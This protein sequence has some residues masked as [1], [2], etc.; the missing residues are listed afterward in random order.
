VRRLA[1]PGKCP[2]RESE[3]YEKYAEEHP[4]GPRTAKALYEAAYRQCV[5]VDMFHADNEDKKADD[6]KGHAH[7]LAARLRDKYPQ[8]DFTARAS[9]LVFKIDQGIPVYG[10]DQQ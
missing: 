2:Q 8:S 3:L 5:L 6:A 10:I 9:A 7:D 1:G 4:D